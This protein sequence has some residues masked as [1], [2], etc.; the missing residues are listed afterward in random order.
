MNEEIIAEYKKL[1]NEIDSKCQR[2]WNIHRAHMKCK[3]GCSQCCQAF[4]ILPVEFHYISLMLKN[5][6]IAINKDFGS[7]QCKFLVNNRC[8]IYEHRPVICRTHGFPLTRLNEEAGAYEVSFCELNFE[9]FKLEKF[10]KNN[11][12]PEDVY[13]SKLYML[14]KKF[15]GQLHETP[16]DSI[17]LLELNNVG[18]AFTF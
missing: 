18:E 14:N 10:N 17:Q 12:F 15:I 16:Y 4:R 6:N 5:K 13:N 7:S 3:E 8:S 9:G 11:V 2:L 1:R